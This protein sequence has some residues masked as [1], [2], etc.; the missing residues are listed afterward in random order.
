MSPIIS[1]TR[2]KRF[3]AGY[4]LVE[5]LVAV[6]IMGIITIG[7]MTTQ[8]GHVRTADSSKKRTICTS[9]AEQGLERML[10]MRFEDLLDLAGSSTTEDYGTIPNFPDYK[11]IITVNAIAG[12]NDFVSIQVE[13][14]WEEAEDANSP[15][16]LRLLR[17]RPPERG[18]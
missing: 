9:L 12:S 7:I 13:A 5:T 6:T 14:F 17:T 11:R 4:S 2:P 8:G 3:S 18:V 16:V 1:K 15:S 10:A